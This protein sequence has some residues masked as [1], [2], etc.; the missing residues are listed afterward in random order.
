MG[1]LKKRAQ[2]TKSQFRGSMLHR[3]LKGLGAPFT[4]E[5]LR[6]NPKLRKPEPYLKNNV[7]AKSEKKYAT[8]S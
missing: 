5:L 8:G 7:E 4:S 2:P 1:P 3:G 6:K